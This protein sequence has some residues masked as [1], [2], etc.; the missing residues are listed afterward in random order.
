MLALVRTN[1]KSNA[2]NQTTTTTQPSADIE[3]LALLKADL[4][5]FRRIQ[6]EKSKQQSLKA[7]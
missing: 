4:Q 2:M 6:E 5:N 3:L 1:S 7:A